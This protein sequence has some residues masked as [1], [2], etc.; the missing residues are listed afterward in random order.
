MEADVMDAFFNLEKGKFY[1]GSPRSTELK[2][3][4]AI[5][6]F[7]GKQRRIKTKIWHLLNSI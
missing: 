6:E 4:L 2:Q 7:G 1:H 3:P 5:I